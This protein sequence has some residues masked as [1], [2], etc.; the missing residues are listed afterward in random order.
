MREV[1][2]QLQSNA[3]LYS[4]CNGLTVLVAGLV[5]V[6]EAACS[7]PGSDATESRVPLTCL[8]FN[9]SVAYGNTVSGGQAGSWLVGSD[10]LEAID[11]H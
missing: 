10:S 7:V 11:L 5:R 8:T 6:K 9:S 3:R 4:Y 1:T 2:N